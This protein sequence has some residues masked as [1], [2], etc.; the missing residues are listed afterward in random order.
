VLKRELASF[1]GA[2]EQEADYNCVRS[3]QFLLHKTLDG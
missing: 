2:A 1:F 3:S